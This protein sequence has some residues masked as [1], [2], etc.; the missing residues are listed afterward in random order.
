MSSMPQDHQNQYNRQRWVEAYNAGASA[1]EPFAP[2]T[3][4]GFDT[5]TPGKLIYQV[6]PC[7]ND[8]MKNA[9]VNWHQEIPVA[10]YGQVTQ[11]T[12]VWIATDTGD[13]PAAEEEWGPTAGEQFISEGRTGYRSLGT[14]D[15]H[16]G[17]TVG[18]FERSCCEGVLALM[19]AYDDIEPGGEGLAYKMEWDDGAGEWQEDGEGNVYRIKDSVW[20]NCVLKNELVWCTP[21]PDGPEAG[22]IATYE[23]IGENGTRRRGVVSTNWT[24]T[25]TGTLSISI[26]GGKDPLPGTIDCDNTEASNVSV[27]ACTSWGNHT[28]MDSGDEVWV[29]WHRGSRQ[30]WVEPHFKTMHAFAD[31][32][33]TMCN[34]DVSAVTITNFGHF[35]RCNSPG[36]VT[37]VQNPLGLLG[38]IGDKVLLQRNLSVASGDPDEWFIVNVAHVSA[39]VTLDVYQDATATCEVRRTWQEIGFMRCEDAQGPEKIF[40]DQVNVVTDISKVTGTA[41]CTLSLATKNLCVIEDQGAGSSL[42]LAFTEI[43]VVIDIDDESDGLYQEK[44]GIWALCVDSTGTDTKV[45]DYTTCP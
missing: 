20:A 24:C 12:P 21:S 23:I 28:R 34:S 41:T 18:L 17:V 9:A 4:T 44:R 30:W 25:T 22:E 16:F 19:K 42:S 13:V 11:D 14:S 2:C 39:D 15:I 6:E 7:S 10:G 8:D 38:K 5:S 35:D 36:T 1:I 31:L 3:I 29:Q 40:G 45:V 33:Q 43:D 37:S 26:W 32:S 27:D